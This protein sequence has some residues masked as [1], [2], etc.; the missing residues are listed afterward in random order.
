MTTATTR[1]TDP[2]RRS[3]WRHHG[4]P[5]GRCASAREAI[6]RAGLAGWNIRKLPLVMGCDPPSCAS[7]CPNCPRP[8]AF[9]AAHGPLFLSSTRTE[10]QKPDRGRN[11]GTTPRRNRMTE[12]SHTT[13]DTA[14]IAGDT[15]SELTVSEQLAAAR[16][17]LA[18]YQERVRERAIQ[19]WRDD[20]WSLQSLNE[21]LEAVGLE[22]YEA[23][24]ITTAGAQIGIRVQTAGRRDDVAS[25]WASLDTLQIRGALCEAI[26]RVLEDHTGGEFS[27]DDRAVTFTTEYYPTERVV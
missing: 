3:P 13:P 10:P 2:T 8:R 7:M 17:E 24:Y 21:T 6:Q 27:L 1:R 11:C 18:H 19:G 14:A 22:P 25:K 26:S 15:D 12:I 23:R 20:N 9:E 4:V 5:V 16:E